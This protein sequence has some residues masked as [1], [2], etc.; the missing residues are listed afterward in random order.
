MATNVYRQQYADGSSRLV[1]RSVRQGRKPLPDD[2]LQTR[3]VTINLTEQQYRWIAEQ[4]EMYNMK[5]AAYCALAASLFDMQLFAA[6][7]CSKS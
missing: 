6:N 1:C 7:N 3:R 2:L 4:A 5:P